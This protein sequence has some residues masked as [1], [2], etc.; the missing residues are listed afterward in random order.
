MRCAEELL[1]PRCVEDLALRQEREDAAAVVVDDH[2]SQV[3]PTAGQRDQRRRVVQR[4]RRRRSARAVGAPVA[5]ATPI[6][7]ATTPSMPLAPRL[8]STRTSSRAGPNHSS[9]RTGIDDAHDQG[10]SGRQ[11]PA[12]RAA[13]TAGSVGAAGGEQRVGHGPGRTSA[14]RHRAAHGVPRA[15]V[16]AAARRRHTA[17]GSAMTANG[18][19]VGRVGDRWPGARR[20]PRPRPMRGEPLGQHLRRRR[21]AEP[22]HDGRHV[23]RRRTTAHGAAQSKR[24]IADSRLRTPERGSA[25]TGQPV[26]VRQRGDCAG[27]PHPAP[28]T[29]TPRWRSSIDTSR[30]T[31]A[32]SSDPGDRAERPLPRAPPS[33][34]GGR[35]SGVADQRLAEREVEVHGPRVGAR[36]RGERPGGQRAPR[37]A[38]RQVGDT[39]CV[40]PA[41]GARRTG[42]P[43]RSSARRRRRA[44]RAGGR[45]CRPASARRPGRPRPPRH[46]S[47]WP[48][49]R[50]C[51][52]ARPARPWP[53]RL[54]ERRERGGPLVV[55]HVDAQLGRSAQGQRQRG[56][57]AA[58]GD[59]GVAHAGAHPLVDEGGAERGGDDGGIGHRPIVASVLPRPLAERAARA[60]PHSNRGADRCTPSASAAARTGWCFVHGFTQ[61]GRSWLPVATGFAARPRGAA[62]RR[63]RS[64]R[65]GVGADRPP[66]HGRPA[67]PDGRRRATYVGYSMGGR[68]CLHLALDLPPPR[69]AAGAACRPRPG[70]ADDA[71]RAARRDRRRRARGERSRTTASSRSSTAGSPS[72][73]STGCTTSP[74]D[75]AD[76]LRNTADGPGDE[77]AHGGHGHAGPGVGPPPRTDDA[78]AGAR[79]RPRHQVRRHR[80]ASSPPAS[81][82]RTSSIVPGAGH[83]V[84]S[85]NRW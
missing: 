50:S 85:S 45:R 83:A 20:A 10:R 17:E 63:T 47:G 78:R 35:S 64:R 72:R 2:D 37:A 41:H 9:A 16:S 79:R 29:I 14:W 24:M 82:A 21:L 65:V 13:A 31:A 42:G 54:P 33:R 59:H 39:R 22:Q 43:G 30:A 23:R 80:P 15:P 73:C 81:P 68:M 49:C 56:R 5:A 60:A 61:T 3:E 52:A 77:P 36:R 66:T 74:A 71:E 70:I 76:R 11:A 12:A 19:E 1:E 25:S 55:E 32:S 62:G 51:T 18:D 67:R 57:A 48:P 34:P 38:R 40:E 53:A 4:A 6:A 27:A 58:G 69:A 8:A 44:A 26:G 75:R 7:V 46:G 84:H 28:A